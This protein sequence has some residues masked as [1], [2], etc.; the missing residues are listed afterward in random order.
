MID[1][2]TSFADRVS[3]FAGTRYATTLRQLCQFANGDRV[4]PPISSCRLEEA[5]PRAAIELLAA[6]V[7]REKVGNPG[8]MVYE[9]SAA[10][11]ETVWAVFA[12]NGR[13]AATVR[14]LP[15]ERS[16]ASQAAESNGSAAT[17]WRLAAPA[18]APRSS[19]SRGH[20]RGG[21]PIER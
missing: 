21:R 10:Q 3:T 18:S 12:S 20:L 15:G 13:L 8:G 19:D 5:V 1:Q 4:W 17:S 9:I 14:W 7:L 11:R 2:A 16:W 6:Q